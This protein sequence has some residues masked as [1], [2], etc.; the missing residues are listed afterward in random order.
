MKINHFL[1]D[2]VQLLEEDNEAFASFNL[3]PTLAWIKFILTD[4]KPN[5]N[6]MRIPK[7]E[8]SNLIATGLY[9]PIKMATEEISPGH[10]GT[11]PIGVITHLKEDKDAGRIR[12]LACLWEKE[13][14]EEV[15]LIRERY[16]AKEPLDLSWEILY[17]DET[18]NEDGIIDLHGTVLRAT[19]LVGE[20]AYDSGR[21]SITE[22]AKP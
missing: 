12:G 17:E 2:S 11:T 4:D 16:S 15:K 5:G 22:V 14:P 7:E 13:R 6:M 1:L 8:F 21:T 10:D 20:P 9:M 18:V 19:T 3:N